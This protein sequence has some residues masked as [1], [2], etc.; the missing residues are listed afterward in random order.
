[1]RACGAL[2]QSLFAVLPFVGSIKSSGGERERGRE[3][4]LLRIT[5]SERGHYLPLLLLYQAVIYFGLGSNAKLCFLF[6]LP[7][8]KLMTNTKL[9]MQILTPNRRIVERLTRLP[10]TAKDDNF[11]QVGR[12]VGPVVGHAGAAGQTDD[13]DGEGAG[14][15]FDGRPPSAACLCC[16]F[17]DRH[18][19]GGGKGSL[20]DVLAAAVA[21]F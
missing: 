4:S 19:G 7:Y 6:E 20:A 1:M 13:G 3:G 11:P 16:V 12:V 10:E 8:L 18:G 15:G 2:S 21:V 5:Q 9:I 14:I 17:G